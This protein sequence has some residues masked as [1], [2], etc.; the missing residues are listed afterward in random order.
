MRWYA[1]F[2]LPVFV[3]AFGVWAQQWDQ[4]DREK[5]VKRF[6]P[7]R[8]ASSTTTPMQVGNGDFAFGADI[9][10]L[11]TFQPFNTMS[12][13]G[14]HN[15]SLPNI[16]GESSPNDYVGLE[17]MSHGRLI[18]FAQPNPAKPAISQWMIANPHRIN[19]GRIGL[20]FVG[21]NVTEASLTNKFQE[22]D[23]Y[24]GYLRSTFLYHG[25]NVTVEVLADPKASSIGV[26][27]ISELVRD[28]KLGVFFD[29]PYASGA[30]KVHTFSFFPEIWFLTNSV[31][32]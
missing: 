24:T 26:R 11:Q 15:D 2:A 30:R 21:G 17:W 32:V 9:T 23:L 7:K 3:W 14:W 19:L 13:W 18:P 27:I 1:Q 16:P 8:N 6:N 5:V 25:S 31:E 29:Y 28:R 20:H 10:G 22:L 4:L 12:S